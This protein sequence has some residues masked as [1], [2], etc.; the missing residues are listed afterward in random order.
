MSKVAIQG[1][2]GSY[3]H[4]AKDLL[5]DKASELIECVGFESVFDSLLNGDADLAVIPVENKIIGK[6]E[7]PSSL[8]HFGKFR[9]LNALFLRVDHVLVGVP[10]SDLNNINTVCSHIAA[11]EQCRRFLTHHSGWTSVACADTAL[12]IHD[13][14]KSKDFKKAAIGSRRAAA[15]YGA[16]ILA[17][18]I[19][20]DN[21]NWTKFYLIKT[22]E[23][24]NAR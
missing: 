2:R 23:L 21:D 4:E 15:M 13:V 24:R 16:E 5:V 9:V 17:E 6:I 8:I 18:N 22:E 12:S 10:G 20:D 3:S 7:P 14:V 19:S 1:I 11:L